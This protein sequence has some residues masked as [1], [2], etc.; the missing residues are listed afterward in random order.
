MKAQAETTLKVIATK[1]ARDVKKL[2]AN[3]I[4]DAAFAKTKEQARR[5]RRIL[6][7]LASDLAEMEKKT[8]ARISKAWKA[9]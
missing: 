5:M 3:K 6:Q 9:H 7:K 8:T 1:L 4:T 2:K